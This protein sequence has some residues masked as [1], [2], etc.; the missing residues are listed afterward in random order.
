MTY[1]SDKKFN[2]EYSELTKIHGEPNHRTI[3][4]ITKELKA[5]AQIQCSDIGGGHYGYL[6]LVIT[7][8]DFLTLPTPDAVVFPVAPAPFTVVAVTTAVQ[9]MIQKSQWETETKAYL[10]Y[11]QMQLVL[12]N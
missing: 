2:S 4:N 8:A 3:L 10:E 11:V 12:K 1:I 5:N 7:E 6:P 9:S